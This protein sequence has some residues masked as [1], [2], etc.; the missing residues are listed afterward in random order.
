MRHPHSKAN[1]LQG[2]FEERYSVIQAGC[3]PSSVDEFHG[4]PDEIWTV[5]L[6][7]LDCLIVEEED[8]VESFADMVNFGKA[9][10][11]HVCLHNPS[12]DGFLLVPPALAEKVLV[13]GG[14]V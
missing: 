3:K 2:L 10:R 9:V 5:F 6:N 7:R 8:L 12:G 11:T 1:K 14:L 4:D 13:M